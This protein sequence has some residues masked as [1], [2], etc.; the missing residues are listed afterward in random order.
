MAP[1][2]KEPGPL[3]KAQKEG[4]ALKKRVITGV[5]A[6]DVWLGEVVLIFI[7]RS[8]CQGT[9]CIEY[10]TNNADDFL[11]LLKAPYKQHKWR[12]IS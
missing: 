3:G 7:N 8:T 6:E 4:D 10:K 2:N 11:Q 1:W 12:G 5:L 9:R